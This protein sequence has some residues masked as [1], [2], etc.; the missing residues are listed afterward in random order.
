VRSGRAI[1]TALIGRDGALGLIEGLGRYEARDRCVA[2]SALTS[3]TISSFDLRRVAHEHRGIEAICVN[4]IDNILSKTE[5][6]AARYVLQTLEV[7]LANCLLDA[8][9]LLSSDTLPF[10]Q[11]LLAEMLATRRTSV[12]EAACKLYEADIIDYSRGVILIQ[13][14]VAL[15]KLAHVTEE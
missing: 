7:R 13:D 6:N 11:D 15:M 3:I 14:R 12:T 4:H 8:S 10:T 9:D 1:D 2:R 5:R